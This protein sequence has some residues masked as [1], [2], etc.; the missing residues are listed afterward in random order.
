MKIKAKETGI[1]DYAVENT[2]SPC[3]HKR[4]CH[5][6]CYDKYRDINHK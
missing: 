5:D 3:V 1:V 2:L 4:Q 6:F